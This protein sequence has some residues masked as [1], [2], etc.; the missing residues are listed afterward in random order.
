[1]PG[2]A[3]A[4]VLRAAADKSTT[5]PSESLMTIAELFL[6]GREKV[7]DEAIAGGVACAGL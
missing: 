3:T 1:M 4:G 7:E 6:G 2:D 5:L